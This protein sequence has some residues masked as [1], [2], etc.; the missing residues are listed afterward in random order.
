MTVSQCF[1]FACLIE[2]EPERKMSG[3]RTLCCHVNT[4]TLVCAILY[5]ILNV[6]RFGGIFIKVSWD[7][8]EYSVPYHES[9]VP[10]GQRVF[11][12]STNILMLVLMAFSAVLVL[13]SQ[14]KRPMC[15]L[16]FMLM[17]FVELT[18]SFLS[19]CDGSWGLPGFPTYRDILQAIKENRRVSKLNEEDIGQLSMWYSVVF[20]LDILLKVY[21][22]R[23]S[24]KCFYFLK[25]KRATAIHVDTGNTVKV[26]LPSYDEALKM[27]EDKPPTYHEP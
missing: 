2:K 14:R 8:V 22:L 13:F 20:M 15:V 10:R 9:K 7:K 3:T 17:M 23:V 26:K 1:S 12:I 24:M 5:L 19:L 11:D 6:L 18:L 27:E 4:A 25:E 21:V 16:P